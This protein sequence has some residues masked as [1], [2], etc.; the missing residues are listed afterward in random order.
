MKWKTMT[1][2]EAYNITR[3]F[4]GFWD[5]MENPSLLKH[6]STMTFYNISSDKK[7]VALLNLN[8]SQ[9]KLISKNIF[10]KKYKDFFS[11][12]IY[13]QSLLKKH[14]PLEDLYITSK[15]LTTQEDFFLAEDI[16]EN[17][18][19][20]KKSDLKIG[21][22]YTSIL[23]K[24]LLFLGDMKVFFTVG[25]HNKQTLIFDDI[26]YDL[27]SKRL[28]YADNITLLEEKNSNISINRYL[29]RSEIEKKIKSYRNRNIIA[30]SFKEITWRPF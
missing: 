23:E 12:D 6:V 22:V 24:D 18:Q 5:R 9:I 19:K 20:I 28:F 27:S 16:M 3:P 15:G 17:L 4:R 14:Y 8:N 2:K 25:H 7:A 1:P 30:N 11:E 10:F 26:L 21:T 13:S 29:P